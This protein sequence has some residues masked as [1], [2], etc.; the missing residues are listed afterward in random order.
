[1]LITFP[2][3]RNCSFVTPTL[4]LALA[5]SV[6]FPLIES[7]FCGDRIVTDGGVK[8]GVKLIVALADLVGSARLVAFT[9]ILSG[10]LIE[11]GAVY[12]PLAESTPIDALSAQVTAVFEVPSTV[13]VNCCG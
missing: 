11:A 2:S 9:V 1:V 6:T 4:S 8:S 7:P 10:V 13:E 12:W 5:E 3:T